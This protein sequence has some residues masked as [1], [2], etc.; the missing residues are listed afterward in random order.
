MSQFFDLASMVL[1][2]S[3]YR[4]GKLYSQKP[5]SSSGE[6]TF[7]RGSD[8]EAT[9]VNANGYIEKAKVNLLLQS[10]SYLTSW[11]V[12]NAVL[13]SG[14]IGYDVSNDAWLLEN[15][16]ADGYITQSA[17]LSAVQTYSVYA[18]AGT[19][20]FIRIRVNVTGTNVDAYFDLS[21]GTYAGTTV[22]TAI[23]AT[24]TSM[25]SGWYRCTLTC[26][27]STTSVRF[28]PAIAYDDLTATSGNIYI[29]D[30]QLNYG[31]VA[32]DY[33]ETQATS[34]V[35]G[36][37][38]DMP[39]LDYSG[40][41]SCP[42]LLLEPQRTNIVTST[43]Y[44]EYGWSLANNA[45]IS[46]ESVT[47]P[48]GSG[49]VTKIQANAGDNAGRNQDSLGLL[50]TNHIWSGFFKGTGVATRLRFRNNQGEQVQYNIDASGNFTLHDAD[51]ANHG[52]EDFPNG[53]KRIWF[54]TT[55]SGASTNYVQI[56]P[57]VENGT[58]SVYAWGIQAEAGSFVTSYIPNYGITS[59]V[60]RT[61][62]S[63][64]LN[65]SAVLPTAYPFTLYA[66]IDVV[67]PSGSGEAITFLNNATYNNYF[68]LLYYSNK[69]AIVSRPSGTTSIHE[70]TTVP[71]IG[72]HKIAGVFTSTQLKIFLDGVLIGTGTN[73]QAFNSAVND[74]L[75]GQLRQVTDGGFRVP[76]RQALVFKN[77]L[78]DADA[79]TL[80]TL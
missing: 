37:T 61:A 75:I 17:T 19:L 60:T 36:I 35:T 27:E 33:V 28:Y 25:G 59:G 31:L 29:Q 32:Q 40:G 45:T 13:N 67:D 2:P 62:D 54:E 79:I 3:G 49:L 10:N 7:S 46:F 53:W 21:T 44:L 55:T 8:I 12:S 78:S 52:I 6:L 24:I 71:T 68:S 72:K 47:A 23:D 30:A 58:G 4:D 56:Y 38:N 42:S 51:S 65:N 63:A 41:A 50:G 64:I 15:T 11:T 5:L 48:D 77:A 22:G 76:A 74:L 70:T 26:N 16:D 69:W 66:E 14:Q 73:A 80:T 43:E 18:K 57:D 34:V 39:R 20:D 1:V 9:R